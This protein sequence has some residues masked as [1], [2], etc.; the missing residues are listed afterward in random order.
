[1]QSLRRPSQKDSLWRVGG[2]AAMRTV[3]AVDGVPHCRARRLQRVLPRWLR[4]AGVPPAVDGHC[5]SQGWYRNRV[6]FSLDGRFDQ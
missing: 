1:M 6:A 3:K 2:P 5:C 4:D